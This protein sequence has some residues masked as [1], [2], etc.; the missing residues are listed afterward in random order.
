MLL[1]ILRKKVKT[2]E[3]EKVEE[4]FQA[5]HEV[6]GTNKYKRSTIRNIFLQLYQEQDQLWYEQNWKKAGIAV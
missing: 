4:S 2:F 1:A 5:C 3:I 6:L